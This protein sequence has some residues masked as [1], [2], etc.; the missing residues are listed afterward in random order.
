MKETSPSIDIQALHFTDKR[1]EG[2][3]ENIL[4]SINYTVWLISNRSGMRIASPT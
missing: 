2:I 1:T 4:T 3:S